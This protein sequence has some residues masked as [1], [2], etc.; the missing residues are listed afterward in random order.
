LLRRSLTV[1]FG[2]WVGV[3]VLSG[4]LV[5]ALTDPEFPK[6]LTWIAGS[7]VLALLSAAM[8]YAVTHPSQTLLDRTLLGRDAGTWLVPK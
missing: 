2:V 5:G 4:F 7:G 3:I 1:W 6:A 8:F